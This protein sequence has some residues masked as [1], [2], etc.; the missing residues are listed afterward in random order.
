MSQIQCD[1]SKTRTSK[2][3]TLVELLVVIGIIALLISIL[4]PALNKARRSANTIVCSSNLHQILQGMLMYAS[5]YDGYIAGSS[6]TSGGFLFNTS[7]NISLN[8]NYSD[9]NC[10]DISQI[11]DWQAPIAKQMGIV[12]NPA[13]DIASRSQRFDFLMTLPVFTCPENQFVAF[14]YETGTLASSGPGSIRMPSYITAWDFLC[15][16]VTA[17]NIKVSGIYS[18]PDNGNYFETPPGYVPKLNKIGRASAKIYI[19]DGGKYTEV[20]NSSEQPNYVWSYDAGGTSGTD[21]G[22]YS[23]YG[24]WEYYSRALDRDGAPLN[25]GVPATSVDSRIYG[26]RHGV[27]TSRG[28]TNAY[29]F[30]AGFFDGHVETLGD[31][32]GADPAMWNPVGTVIQQTE[33][34]KDVEQQY[35][36]NHFPY[37]AP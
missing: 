23:D 33:F 16:P 20:T 32:E 10:P 27:Q 14:D 34:P 9:S 22:A 2:A 3:F 29:R 26:F 35:G 18:C 5:Q 30:N 11:W 8:T 1:A 24:A 21:G 25:G 28:A 4:L 37:V 13:S 19:A 7:G 36:I 17:R 12:F 15:M 31:L 6:A